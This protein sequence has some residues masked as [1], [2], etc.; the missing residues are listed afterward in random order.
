MPSFSAGKK[1]ESRN[2]NVIQSV[3]SQL[4]TLFKGRDFKLAYIS[5]LANQTQTK[6]TWFAHTRSRALRLRVFDWRQGE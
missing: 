6:I 2:R 3:A 1:K 4:K 5:F